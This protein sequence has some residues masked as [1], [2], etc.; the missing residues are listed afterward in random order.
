[1]LR[2]N[3]RGRGDRAAIG[4][5]HPEVQR[6]GLDA[7]ALEQRGQRHAGP[8]RRA[9]RAEPPLHARRRRQRE[10]A[11]AVA[12]AL[13]R[14]APTLGA[15]AANVREPE[16]DRARHLAVD[17]QRPRRRGLGRQREMA[18]NEEQIVSR[19]ERPQRFDRRFRVERPR[20]ADDQPQLA[21]ARL[22]AGLV[23][24]RTGARRRRVRGASAPAAARAS[25]S[26]SRRVIHPSCMARQ[27]SR[28]QRSRAPASRSAV[29][30][31]PRNAASSA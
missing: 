26:A 14:R 13:D 21:R 29:I 28:E 12:G 15:H 3:T 18:A 10:T 11:A 24:R 22:G 31:R 4:R 23:L 20:I 6:R 5:F 27:S 17:G 7:G 2:R 25:V 9:H 8:C 1:M 30:G 16:R 19:V